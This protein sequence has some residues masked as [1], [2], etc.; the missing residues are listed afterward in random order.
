MNFD[1]SGLR[2]YQ[3][4]SAEK[5]ISSLTQHGVAA[6]GSSTG[7]GKT[8]KAAALVRH[9]NLPTLVV[10]PKSIRS[11]WQDVAGQLG[12]ELDTINYEMLRTGRTPY[13]FWC[14]KSGFQYDLGVGFLVFDE[15]HRCKGYGTQNAKLLMAA[16]RQRVPTLVMSATLAESP[17]DMRALGYLLGLHDYTG[18]WRWARNYGCKSGYFGGMEF[19]GHKYPGGKLAVMQAL[20][21]QIF[22]QRGDRVRIADLPDFP[23]TQIS[24]ELCDIAEPG[25]VDALYAEMADALA[26]LKVTRKQDKDPDHP[27]TKLLRARQQVELLKVPGL[28]DAAQDGLAAGNAVC[29][30]VQFSQTVDELQVRLDTD[31]VFDG[32]LSEGVRQANHQDFQADRSPVFITQEQSGGEAIDLHDVTGKRP[33]LSLISPGQSAR[34]LRQIFGRVHRDGAQTKSVQQVWFAANTVEEANQKRLRAKLNCLDAL[35]DADLDANNL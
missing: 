8:W 2:P 32:R 16:R 27:L 18:F 19:T 4:A 33:R 31:C 11:K 21:K 7:T 9:F 12:T 22:E 25:K 23:Q 29:L 34:R 15:V 26:E 1:S 6:D 5:L 10:C 3:A 14:N 30:F 17:L 24:A 13:G 28:V 35:N 20:H